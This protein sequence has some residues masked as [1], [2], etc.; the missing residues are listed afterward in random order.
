[1]AYATGKFARALCDRCGFEYKLN[2]LKEEWNGA[3]TCH[4]CYETKHPQ[5]EPPKA[6]SDPEALYKP[7]PNND[8]EGGEGFIVVSYKNSTATN[9]LD[10]NILGSNFQGVTSTASV[11]SVTTTENVPSNRAVP[12]GVSGTSAL[13]SVS[14]TGTTV[15]ETLTGQAGTLS[16][17]TVSVTTSSVTTYTVTVA[18]GTNSY[19]YGNKYYLDGSLSPTLNLSEGSTYRFD[20]SDSSNSG[21]PL[22]F[23]TTANGTHGGGSEYTTGVTTSGTPGSSGAY[24][25]ITVAS[26][27]PTLYYYCT[28]HSGMG[29]TANTP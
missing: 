11:G 12:D 29:G 2:E 10:E 26:G 18:T 17:G 23:S 25:Q 7:R 4:S 6:K 28:N 8:V 20:Q 16:L 3:K 27:A 9:Y 5:L 15:N 1:M 14:V 19:G 21:H 24:T 13:G 22:R